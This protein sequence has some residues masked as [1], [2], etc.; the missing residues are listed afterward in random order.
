MIF[1]TG[2]KFNHTKFWSICALTVFPCFA[3]S[4][5]VLSGNFQTI[6]NSRTD[7]L[8]VWNSSEN[9][10]IFV[11]DFPGLTTQGRTFNRATQFTEQ[12]QANL[13]YPRVLGN[14]EIVQYMESLRRTQANFAFGHDLLVSE[15]VQF[16]NLADRDK[17]SLFPEELVLRDFMIEQGLM[18]V[19]R[20]FYQAI[21]P[22]VVILSIPQMQAKKEDEPPVSELA[23]RAIFTHEVA[24]GEYYTN[25]YYANYCRR[26]WNET[27]KDSQREAFINLFKKYNY[28]V[29]L[30]ELVVN[31]MQ[32]YLMFTPDPNSFNARK[33]GITDNELESMRDMFRQGNPPTKLPLR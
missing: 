17:I 19:W 11:F 30:S 13:G 1:K 26:F 22:D 4:M 7:A 5:E 16:Y 15:L 21:Q 20:S 12:Q 27:L 14:D 25:Q 29:N 31:E 23:R 10:K 32:A 24:H 28:A 18:K 9:P 6:L 33:L 8:T 2:L 3:W